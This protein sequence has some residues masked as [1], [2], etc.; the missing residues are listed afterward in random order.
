MVGHRRPADGAEEDGVMPANLPQAVGRHHPA[1]A[2]LEIPAP[3]DILPGQ[4]EAVA[5]GGHVEHDAGSGHHLLADAVAFDDR[6]AKLR[7]G[8]LRDWVLFGSMVA[9]ECDIVSIHT[10]RAAPWSRVG[11]DPGSA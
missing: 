5:A 6:D 2:L 10:H 7:H 9:A 3:L 8:S 4:L 11:A 1:P